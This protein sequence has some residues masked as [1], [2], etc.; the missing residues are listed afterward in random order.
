MFRQNYIAKK[1]KLTFHQESEQR[2]PHHENLQ[3]LQTQ[4]LVDV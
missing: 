2:L 1:I 4:S 3:I